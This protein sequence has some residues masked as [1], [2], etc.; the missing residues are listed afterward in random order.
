MKSLKKYTR[1]NAQRTRLNVIEFIKFYE[2]FNWMH[3]LLMAWT[4]CSPNPKY[5]IFFFLSS[6]LQFTNLQYPWSVLYFVY[7]ICKWENYYKF[8]QNILRFLQTSLKTTTFLLRY[9]YEG[10]NLFSRVYLLTIKVANVYPYI[11]NTFIRNSLIY[12]K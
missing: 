5:K 6:R 8:K 7:V 3:S 9:I 2:L 10:S 11:Y 1:L 12:R 4:Y